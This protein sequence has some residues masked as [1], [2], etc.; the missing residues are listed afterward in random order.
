MAFFVAH[1]RVRHRD[2]RPVLGAVAVKGAVQWLAREAA[3]NSREGD[4]EP[5]PRH[6]SFSP[7]PLQG[8]HLVAPDVRRLPRHHAPA[9]R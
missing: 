3:D 7:T 6:P 4:G 8:V 2:G 5:R 9:I 1:R